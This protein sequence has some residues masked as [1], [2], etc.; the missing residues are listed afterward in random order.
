M[1]DYILDDDQIYVDEYYDEEG[2]SEYYD[3][4]DVSLEDTMEMAFEE[5][6]SP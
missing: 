2:E 1:E 5:T 6:D 3:E 4:E